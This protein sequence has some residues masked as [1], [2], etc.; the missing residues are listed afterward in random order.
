MYSERE[1]EPKVVQFKNDSE[2]CITKNCR[3]S[4]NHVLGI[5]LNMFLGESENHVLGININMFLGE[6]LTSNLITSI[7]FV[8]CLGIDHTT[9]GIIS[10]TCPLLKTLVIDVEDIINHNTGVEYDYKITYEDPSNTLPP[11]NSLFDIN[12]KCPQLEKLDL[13]CTNV[14]IIP[15]F[16]N[17]RVL[18]IW[19][20][21]YDFC[22]KN[23]NDIIL[24]CKNLQ[25]FL[26]S[27]DGMT[28]GMDE[29]TCKYIAESNITNVSF[30]T[31][32]D[33]YSSY[34]TS[35]HG[36]IDENIKFF[37]FLLEFGH[38]SPINEDSIRHDMALEKSFKYIKNKKGLTY[39]ILD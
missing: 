20:N 4:E 3:E 26:F 9:I 14:R 32:N 23:I 37:E 19:K 5:N 17:I 29:N 10:E 30:R 22:P 25:E 15:L 24:K 38:I 33:Y 8:D 18:K 35:F 16:V 1:P 12:K 39:E 21:C 31:T 2:L 34:F 7:S 28:N 27:T 11:L 36:D 13:S 6:I